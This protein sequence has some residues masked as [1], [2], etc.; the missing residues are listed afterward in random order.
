MTS[1]FSHSQSLHSRLNT[2]PLLAKKMPRTTIILSDLPASVFQ[3]NQTASL[4]LA[5]EIKI[6]VLNSN[7]SG[8]ASGSAADVACQIYYFST[9][10]SLQRIVIVF[11]N[12]SI[13][14]Q[15]YTL[16]KSHQT[17]N[18][19]GKISLSE[20]LIKP[21]ISVNNRHLNIDLQKYAPLDGNFTNGGVDNN[22][23]V[24]DFIANYEEPMPEPADDDKDIED[25]INNDVGINNNS[26]NNINNNS[27][28]G[29]GLD[30]I[31][32]KDSSS[33]SV[34][35]KGSTKTLLKS[36]DLKIDTLAGAATNAFENNNN[37]DGSRSPAS[38]LI[39]L[40]NYE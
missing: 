16:L 22:G 36:M 14:S 4:S 6:F 11:N 33:A 35:S 29:S 9:L 37:N 18:S 39:T 21:P 40:D 19:L 1:V 23:R 28:S 32:S 38:P 26:N 10:A 5:D 31:R 34:N 24:D 25:E 17:F 20:T 30:K 7:A 15:I 27:G 12:E 3:K 8:S 13:A 2:S